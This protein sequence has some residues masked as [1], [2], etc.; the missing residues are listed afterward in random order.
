MKTLY[1][2]SAAAAAGAMAVP[3]SAQSTYPYQSYPVQ[4]TYPYA[5]PVPQPVGPAEPADPYLTHRQCRIGH[6][7]GKRTDHLDVGM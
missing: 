4:Q 7:A 2:L 6:P 3:A 5:Q 1:L